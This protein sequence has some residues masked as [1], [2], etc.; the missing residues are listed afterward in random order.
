MNDYDVVIIGAGA[1]GMMAAI[2]AGR[3][4]ASVCIVEKNEKPG[5]KIYITGKGR[6]NIT[7]ACETE[8]LFHSVVTN[9]KF[10]YSSFYAFTNFDV[11]DFFEKAGVRCKVERGN[12]VFPVSDKSSDV[13]RALSAEC[14]KSGVKI[15]YHSRAAK[16]LTNGKGVCGVE[17]A[18]GRT[19]MAG[20][21]IVTTGGMSYPGTGSDGDGY[22]FASDTG[23]DIVPCI[24]GLVPMNIQGNLAEQ[25][26]GLSL[27]NVEMNFYILKENGKKKELY[28]EFGEMMFTH[29]GMTGPIILSAS[30]HIGRELEKQTVYAELD[31]KP[32]LSKE[33]LH[34]R[35]IRDFEA[36]PNVSLK[37]SLGALLPKSM[38]PVVLK[39][40]GLDGMEAVNQ[41]TREERERLVDAIKEMTF[42]VDSLRGWKEAIIT[43]GGVSVKQ[44]NPSTMESKR[45]KNLYFAGE[46]IDVDAVTGGFNLQIAWSTGYLA[47]ESAA[48][49]VLGNK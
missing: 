45:V 31:C 11:V 4:G 21:V 30:C 39:E 7:N 5:K 29:F 38:I 46:V 13:I 23:H 17:C 35:I 14:E 48:N 20:G 22:Q 19:I 10:L 3:L 1:A 40:A 42:V 28:R 47:G 9:K 12:R 41:V 27:K 18:D 32:A 24:Q 43:R 25:M 37:N 26:Q 49:V 33:K 6:C 36:A 16:I 2:T 44:I 15:L 8:D 34:R